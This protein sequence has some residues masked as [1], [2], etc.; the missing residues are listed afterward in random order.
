MRRDRKLRPA[1]AKPVS[2]ANSVEISG[3]G[4]AWK[5]AGSGWRGQA[6]TDDSPSPHEMHQLHR[7]AIGE[8]RLAQAGAADDLPIQLDHH[9]ARV[10][11]RA[12]PADPAASPERELGADSPFTTMSISV[13]RPPARAPAAP[14][15]RPRDRAHPTA[16]RWRLRRRPP[17]RGAARARAGV[18]PPIAITGRPSAATS[19]TSA[20]PTPGQPGCDAV[21]YTLPR[22]RKSAPAADRLPGLRQA[23]HRAA[24]PSR[25]EASAAR[26]PLKYHRRRAARPAPR[27]PRRDRAGR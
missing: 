10:E 7:V 3:V 23:V 24:D 26:L 19:R 6:W 14:A 13:M 12:V 5:I 21:S 15:R 16:P 17:R 9:G 22:T 25:R 20:R 4:H 2:S 27:S 8:A 18:T 11:A 1:M